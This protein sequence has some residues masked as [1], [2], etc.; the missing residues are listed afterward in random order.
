MNIKS[1][2]P[3]ASPELHEVNSQL[4]AQEQIFKLLVESVIDYGIFLMDPNG[5]IQSWNA[6]AE[7]IEGYKASEIIGKHFSIFYLDDDIQRQHPQYEIKQAALHGRYEEEG[8][9]LKKDKS[10]F[11]ASIVITSLRNTEGK[12]IGFA[13][14]TRDL[15]E[16]KEVEMQLR[17]SEERSRRMF[18]GIKDYSFITLNTDGTVAS[19]NEGAR[20][21]KGYEKEE[22]LGKYFS[23]FYTE[24]DIQMGKCEYELREASETGRFEDT[25]W[26]VRKDGTKFWASV[27]ITAIR[28]EN[29]NI[30]GFSKVTRDITD[31]KR[32][33]DLLRM[34]YVNLE[35]RVEER[36]KEISET[37]DKLQKA[38]QVRDEFLSIASHELRTPLTPLKLQ[39]QSLAANIRKKTYTQIN[40]DRLQK[41]ADTC[42]KAISRLSNLVDNL[43][44]V[45]RINSGKLKLYFE[46]FDLIEL[47]NEIIDR[48]RSDISFSKSELTVEGPQSLIG[49]FDR[50]RIEQIFLNLL[51]NSLKYGKGQ[52][53]EI[54]IFQES[55]TVVL[56]FIDRGMGIKQ[57]DMNRIFERFERLNPETAIG[58]LGLGLYITRQIVEAHG[59]S[60]KVSS[61]IDL[62][63]TFEVRLPLESKS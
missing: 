11:W 24:D 55:N 30:I 52:P 63:S 12:L 28:N 46:E 26:R 33:E 50:L 17:L 27:L 60:I 14:V 8:W 59:G 25:G 1:S 58:G 45:S 36:T 10:K 34:S 56:K 22:I 43:L 20:R 38:I 41:M 15:T 51:T 42:N 62:G 39:I 31:K 44:D 5:F 54:K 7:K 57:E 18:E 16:K 35:K 32:A 9:R 40:E 19:W 2:Q 6:G 53:I 21:I 61:Q 3:K 47:I 4:A 48:H 49:V 13:K 29:G 23:I 37:N